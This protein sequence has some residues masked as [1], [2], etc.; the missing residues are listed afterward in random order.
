MSE[1]EQRDKPIPK[2][3]QEDVLEAK[4]KC[5][6][7]DAGAGSG[8]TTTMRWRIEQLLT[9]D[10]APPSDRV[11][12]LTFANEAA[13]TIQDRITEA[14]RLSI[15]Q[16]HNIDVHTYHSFCNRIISEYAYV[17][18][19]DPDFDIITRDQRLRI[20]RSLI[21]DND[22]QYVSRRQADTETVVEQAKNYISEMR[23][24]AI[25]PDNVDE[26]LP[27]ELAIRNLKR[28]VVDLERS[29]QLFDTD[30][31]D[32]VDDN[33]DVDYDTLFAHIE[34]YQDTL[35]GWRGVARDESGDIWDSVDTYLFYME[36]LTDMVEK[37][38]RTDSDTALGFLPQALLYDDVHRG[39]W[40]DIFQT[41]FGHLKYYI[42]T[43]EEIYELQRIYH[44]YVDELDSRGALDFDELIYKADTLI[45]D[46]TIGNEICSRWDYVFCDEF[47]DTDD[48]QIDVVTGLCK[49]DTQLLAI[50]D[51][52]QAIYGW[53]GANPEGLNDLGD[54]FAE[55][56]QLD[57]NRNFRSDQ[58]ILEFANKCAAYDSKRLISEDCDATTRTGDPIVERQEDHQARLGLVDGEWT[59]QT[60]AEEVTTTISQL[61]DDGFDNIEGRSL[62]DIAVIVRKNEQA[63]KVAASLRS[64]QI[65]YRIDGSGESEIGTGIQT[66]L[67]YFRVLID[68]EADM[69]LR[70][71]LMLVYRVTED[72]INALEEAPVDSLY[73]AV[74]N[75]DDIVSHSLVDPDSVAKARSDLQY[76]Y[77][78]K[79]VHSLPYFYNAF[80]D[81]TRIQWYLKK[82]DRAKLDRIK[83]FMQAYESDNVLRRFS[84]GFVD[85]L[86][87]SLSGRHDDRMVGIASR[88]DEKVNVLTVHQAK[89]LQFDTVLF[90]YLE[91]DEWVSPTNAVWRAHRYN[92]IIRDIKDD[93]FT[94]PLVE[95]IHREELEEQWRTI[96]VGV[97]RAE[98]L[99]ILFSQSPK[100]I[101]DHKN[102]VSDLRKQCDQGSLPHDSPGELLEAT[103][104][105]V[106]SR[107]SL[108]QPQ[109]QLWD[110]ITDAFKDVED[111]YPET[112]VN[113]SREVKQAANAP[114]GT[115]TFFNRHEDELNLR[116]AISE[117][118]DLGNDIFEEDLPE[119]NPTAE[120]IYP[121]SLSFENSAE[122]PLQHSHT[123]IETY[124][125][126][127]RR[128][129]LDHVL[130]GFDDP[131]PAD[132]PV[133][134]SDEPSWR[135]VGNVFH[136]VAEEAFYR[137]ETAYDEWLTICDRIIR[138]RD[139]E[140]VRDEVEACIRRIFS[141]NLLD[142]EPVAAE[143]E[144]EMADIPGV[145]GPVIGYIDSV[146]RVP[147][148]G[149][150]VLDY[151]TTFEKRDL[152]S[153]SQLL[154]YLRACE[155]LFDESVDWA[156]YVYVGEAGGA[157]GEIDL[158]HRDDIEDSWTDVVDL[159]QAADSPSWDANPGSHCRHCPHRSLGCAPEEHEYDN[160]FVIETDD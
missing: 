115:I 113:L 41:P 25:A 38:L 94:H 95:S 74:I 73:D 32:L 17:L 63:K 67:S 132:A 122:L 11:L 118:H 2:G 82:E 106:D 154:L 111:R 153:S 34:E 48:A 130:Y 145:N 101:A 19:I 56:E 52:D 45:N 143:L 8:K 123:S 15:D 72:D 149:L 53:R 49:N 129:L 109:M 64:R 91:D 18:G 127:P 125:D 136:A 35:S 43:L 61:L 37:L 133:G 97:T 9:A 46:S 1:S 62:G 124:S 126:C 98:S 30:K 102:T 137:N 135:N 29:A 66:I 144:F 150:A 36:Q 120:D 147:G 96:H 108:S 76:L 88:S 54:D 83:K 114:P 57:I 156:G 26:Y 23:Q 99:L 3:G 131:V 139:L 12:V 59:R 151:K 110:A 138:A 47:Q 116:Q 158:I 157:D 85:S 140:S 128:H 86:A 146:R 68:P 21:E 70:R 78:L 10:D 16:A 142:W 6:S 7:V 117:I 80:L 13:S 31:Y 105:D 121:S 55:S 103:F 51:V 81:R 84:E 107:W 90:P 112:V 40:P 160:E 5:I 148:K 58:E 159:L 20:V 44:D 60:T 27:E 155:V 65:P 28:L 4:K 14:K 93:E 33:Y 42:E 24:E 79:D 100:D 87:E 92:S 50:G 39:W 134:R 77:E 22:Y 71:V 69:H 75:H 104:P 152:H 89:G 141:T 119:R